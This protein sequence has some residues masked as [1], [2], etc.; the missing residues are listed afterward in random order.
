MNDAPI[1]IFDSGLGGLSVWREVVKL[2]P[3]E[4]VMYYGDG[5]NCP[6]GDKSAELIKQYACSAWIF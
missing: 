2:L 1:G 6:Y 5:K 3:H 4:S